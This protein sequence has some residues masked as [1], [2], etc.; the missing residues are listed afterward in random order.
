MTKE[1]N[2]KLSSIERK[3]LE[4]HYFGG[5]FG[6]SLRSAVFGDVERLHLIVE[7]GSEVAIKEEDRDPEIVKKEREWFEAQ[8]PGIIFWD[9]IKQAATFVLTTFAVLY[10]IARYL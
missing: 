7:Q 2:K 8:I 1:L 10:I 4:D 9:R 3:K 6:E 5:F